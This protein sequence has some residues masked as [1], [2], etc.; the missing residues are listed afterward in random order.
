MVDK[1]QV[2]IPVTDLQ[3]QERFFAELVEHIY[4]LDNKVIPHI[5]PLAIDDT[6]SDDFKL[7]AGKINE[8]IEELKSKN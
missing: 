3:L 4:T 5:E 1:I 6:K 8:L 2:P 7:L